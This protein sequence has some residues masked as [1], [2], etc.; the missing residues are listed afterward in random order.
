VPEK[1]YLRV[2]G[3]G[4]AA[5]SGYERRSLCPEPYVCTAW[6]IVD[7]THLCPSGY[8]GP[9]HDIPVVPTAIAYLDRLIGVTVIHSPLV[10]ANEADK[11]RR[12]DAHPS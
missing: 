7:R 4:D 1:P 2:P 11:S 3:L 9:C 8:V 12:H 6:A 10:P 5:P